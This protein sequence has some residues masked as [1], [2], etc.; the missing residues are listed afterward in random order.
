[1]TYIKKMITLVFATTL[2]HGTEAPR[3]PAGASEN[4]QVSEIDAVRV[5]DALKV[6][7]LFKPEQLN[8]RDTK[9]AIVQAIQELN[10]L[11][12]SLIDTIKQKMTLTQELIAFSDAGKELC[13]VGRA[14]T[15]IRNPETDQVTIDALAIQGSDL[16]IPGVAERLH[17]EL[18][19]LYQNP[20]P[21]FQ[22]PLARKHID[23]IVLTLTMLFLARYPGRF[24]TLSTESG[25]YELDL[26]WDAFEGFKQD[27]PTW[28]LRDYVRNLRENV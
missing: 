25:N 14:V 24:V 18:G 8:E 21:Q 28:N 3:P 12:D 15:T 1:M 27:F 11:Q 22:R 5:G 9:Q 16:E 13:P 26:R 10:P 6:L 17:Y 23:R 2:A 4:T 20:T 19:I 7:H